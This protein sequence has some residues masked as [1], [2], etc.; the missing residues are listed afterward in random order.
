MDRQFSLTYYS[1]FTSDNLVLALDKVASDSPDIVIILACP[2][3]EFNTQSIDSII[4]K[5]DTPLYGGIF[6]G[7]IIDSKKITQGFLL[8]SMTTNTPAI[9]FENISTLGDS[10]ISNLNFAYKTIGSSDN[11]LVFADGFSRYNEPF[12]DAFFDVFG[13]GIKVIG[14]GAGRLPVSN[15]PNLFTNKGMTSDSIQVISLPKTL[16]VSY[17]HGWQKSSP[18]YLIT[19]TSDNI[20]HSINYQPAYEFYAN[21]IQQLGQQHI[22]EQNF[23]DIAK[24]FPVGIED[25]NGEI[26]VR[27]PIYVQNSNLY[28]VGDIVAHSMVYILT[29]DYKKLVNAAKD[30]AA[31]AIRKRNQV[32][33][34]HQKT[35][36]IFDCISREYY[37][38]DDFE[39]E[40]QAIHQ[41]MNPNELI[42]GVLS[43]G[44]IVS[45][46]NGTLALLNKSV[47]IGSM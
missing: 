44:E 6:P 17:G 30:T 38:S 26:L 23:S 33:Q 15:E 37:L 27:D 39:S 5:S 19:E 9:L 47:V 24:A 45:N 18:P 34:D 29:G 35:S 40:L 41:E 46:N 21:A 2:N 32:N 31:A 1:D 7:L 12:I 36:I 4:K 8:I 10:L 42:F 25:V 22:N 28:C 11:Y 3:S 43:I 20:L 14:G 13:Q 16:A